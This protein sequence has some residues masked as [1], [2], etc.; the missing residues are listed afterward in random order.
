MRTMY[1]KDM[2]N[3]KHV[4]DVTFV[5]DIVKSLDDSRLLDDVLRAIPVHRVE[6]SLRDRKNTG[7]QNGRY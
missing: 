2:Y 5:E 7:E 3:E 6:E 1:I 4:I